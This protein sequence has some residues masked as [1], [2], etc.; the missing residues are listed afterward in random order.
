M[1]RRVRLSSTLHAFRCDGG[2]TYAYARNDAQSRSK[3][4]RKAAAWERQTAH[5]RGDALP[6]ADRRLQP[7]TRWVEAYAKRLRRQAMEPVRKALLAEVGPVLRQMA[8]E[9]AAAKR[10]DASDRVARLQAAIL[11]AATRLRAAA[12]DVLDIGSAVADYATEGIKASARKAFA[13]ELPANAQPK[14]GNLPAIRAI[15]IGYNEAKRAELQ[16]WAAEQATLVSSIPATSLGR[17]S[18]FVAKHVRDGTEVKTIA[19]M[20][21][22]QFQIDGNRAELIARTEVAKLNARVSQSAA[23]R[24]GATEYVWRT[25]EDERVRGNPSGLYPNPTKSGKPAADHYVLD[26]T[27]HSIDDPP[28]NG[29]NGEKGPPGTI[30]NCRCIAEYLFPEPDEA[31]LDAALAAG[32]D[33]PVPF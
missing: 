14:V 5:L 24:A 1:V 6:P 29:L 28:V 22:E 9:E 2:P 3:A 11:L 12:L 25:C 27:V 23:Q 33:E 8:R 30:Y 17:L 16:V 18:E 32:G 21:D 26:G 4:R 19:K 10:G 31:E 20:L 13:L 7:P 15:D